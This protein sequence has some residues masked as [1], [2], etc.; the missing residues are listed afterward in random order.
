MKLRLIPAGSFLPSRAIAEVEVDGNRLMAMVYVTEDVFTEA[1]C[2]AL[3]V[4]KFATG[5]Y[6]NWSHAG[7]GADPAH[8]FGWQLGG[9]AV[10]G[11][12]PFTTSLAFKSY[13]KQPPLTAG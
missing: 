7:N 4:E 6:V 2:R 12:Y 3:L 13:P 9:Q 5:D 10:G 1:K 8:T 11:V